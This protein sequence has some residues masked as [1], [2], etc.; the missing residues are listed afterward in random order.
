MLHEL[1]AA[2]KGR[3]RLDV[4]LLSKELKDEMLMCAG[5][6]SLCYMDLR[7]EASP[8]LIASDASSH[9]R[10]AAATKIGASATKELQKFGLQKGLWNRLLSPSKAILKKHGMLEEDEELPG[11]GEHYESHPL[12]QEVA[13]SQQFKQFGKLQR[14][15]KNQ[16]INVS[17]VQADLEAEEEHGRRHPNSYYV[18]LVDSQVAAACLVKGR[19]SSWQLNRLLR[20]SLVTHLQSWMQALLRLHQES[21]TLLVGWL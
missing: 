17:E 8:L 19:S 16:H 14:H 1:Y 13:C 7:L 18:H 21:M 15:T 5:L 10:A 9:T 12:W 6:L 3:L 20:Q 2:Q 4:V 11:E